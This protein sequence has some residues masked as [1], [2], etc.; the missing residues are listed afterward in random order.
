MSIKIF[1]SHAT[2]DEKLATAHVDCIYSCMVP[3]DDEVRCTSVP[4]HKLPIG[5][6]GNLKHWKTLKLAEQFD[7]PHCVLIDSDKGANEEQMNIDTI[8]ELQQNGIKAYLT[9]KREPENYIHLDCLNLPAGS[10]F[11]FTE[12]CDAK[13]L[14]A[15][16]KSTK[17]TLIL[18]TYWTRM[19]SEQIREVEMYDDNGTNKYEFTEM[20]TDFLSLVKE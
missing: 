16:E 2:A 15:N 7:I 11:S 20:F 8:D 6:C 13:V 4:G 3:D 1:I 19:T 10:T 5:G 18:E 14:I 9:R 12:T 17:K